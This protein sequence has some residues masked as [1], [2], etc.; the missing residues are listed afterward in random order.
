MISKRINK[1]NK[2]KSLLYVFVYAFG[3]DVTKQMKPIK[4]KPDRFT[5]KIKM[6]VKS[7]LNPTPINK[8]AYQTVKRVHL[9]KRSTMLSIANISEKIFSSI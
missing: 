1:L 8:T 5:V 2:V 7:L 4:I 9:I 6:E 3:C